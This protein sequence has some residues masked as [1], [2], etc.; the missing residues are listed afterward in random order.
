MLYFGHGND[1]YEVIGNGTR[2]S[3]GFL[4]IKEFH[5]S[6][7][8]RKCSPSFRFQNIVRDMEGESNSGSKNVHVA[9]GKTAE[10]VMAELLR[11][12]AVKIDTD[13]GYLWRSGRPS[14]IYCD[15]RSLISSSRSREIV[16]PLLVSYIRSHFPH[17]SGIIGVATGGIPYGILSAEK[18]K[19]DFGYVRPQAKSHG[20]GYSLEGFLEKKSS[21]VVFEDVVS[22]AQ[23]ALSGLRSVQAAGY[24]VKGIVT[25]FLYDEKKV[26]AALLAHKVSL[27]ALAS[28]HDLFSALQSHPTYSQKDLDKVY[29][30]L[31]KGEAFHPR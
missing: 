28:A 15:N 29:G 5:G 31:F 18:M 17:I 8:I 26:S 6:I 14:P 12:G 16:L 13:K 24:S 22:T 9:G 25:L 2:R 27:Y 21:V 11:L 7:Q 20:L 4:G 19:I 10:A 3:E 30:F 23:S 1:F